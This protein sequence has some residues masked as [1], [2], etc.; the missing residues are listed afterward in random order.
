MTVTRKQIVQ[1]RTV[2]SNA[3]VTMDTV[4]LVLHAQV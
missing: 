4:G 2:H 3:P 1:T